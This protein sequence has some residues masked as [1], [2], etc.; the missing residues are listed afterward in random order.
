MAHTASYPNCIFLCP[1]DYVL[2]VRRAGLSEE[3][4]LHFTKVKLDKAKRHI[5]SG[6]RLLV[7]GIFV[8]ATGL[9]FRL[10]DEFFFFIFVTPTLLPNGFILG[11]TGLL[12]SIYGV[13]QTGRLTEQL[14]ALSSS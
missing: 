8:T 1:G 10:I 2:P 5:R 14:K 3:A 9:F 6:Y 11:G 4:K 7:A 13:Y 12:E